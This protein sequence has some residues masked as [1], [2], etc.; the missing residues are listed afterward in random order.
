MILNQYLNEIFFY[1]TTYS[2]HPIYTHGCDFQKKI[3][4]FKGQAIPV[5]GF[6]SV[7]HIGFNNFISEEMR[8]RKKRKISEKD[9]HPPFSPK[10]LGKYID[11]AYIIL[12]RWYKQSNIRFSRMHR[13]FFFISWRVWERIESRTRNGE[14]GVD[15]YTVPRVARLEC[16]TSPIS[17]LP[18]FYFI[19]SFCFSYPFYFAAVRISQEIGFPRNGKGAGFPPR[20]GEVWNS[21]E[22]Q[23]P[24]QN[25]SRILG[26]RLFDVYTHTCTCVYIADIIV[27]VSRAL[28]G[29]I[30]GSLNM[31]VW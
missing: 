16:Q 25:V 9:H 23:S 20:N 28:S 19:R 22:M 3:P 24:S 2:G 5:D 8:A 11:A 18:F 30:S 1:F 31:K 14:E 6:A 10:T 7:V 26:S 29:C 17:P 15:L 27:P 13:I 12:R 4:R 21:K